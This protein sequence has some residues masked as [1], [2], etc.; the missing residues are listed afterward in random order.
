MVLRAVRRGPIN[1]PGPLISV[2]SVPNKTKENP[3]A[4]TSKRR[5][6]CQ[7]S[8]AQRAPLRSSLPRLSRGG[9]RGD[10][11]GGGGGGDRGSRVGSLPRTQHLE[12]RTAPRLIPLT[13]PPLRGRSQWRSWPRPEGRPVGA[14]S[15][16][17]SAQPAGFS[18]F[19]SRPHALETVGV[20]VLPSGTRSPLRTRR[21][22]MP[23]A[24][25]RGWTAFPRVHE[26]TEA[27]RRAGGLFP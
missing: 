14:P 17:S 27:L 23:R 24:G 2:H 16:L 8:A 4:P 25:Y 10:G 3:A 18:S 19:S 21:G 12:R 22:L 11:G 6:G 9:S 20:F 5:E 1:S 7:R 26:E 13:P 15:P